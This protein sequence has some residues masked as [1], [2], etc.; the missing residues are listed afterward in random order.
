MSMKKDKEEFAF[1][2]LRE[3]LEFAEQLFSTI[4]YSHNRIQLS[5]QKIEEKDI[6][7]I[8]QQVL[9]LQKQLES[10]KE[11]LTPSETVRLFFEI[12]KNLGDERV[13]KLIKELIGGGITK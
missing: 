13:Q 12:L 2:E 7:D 11:E 4:E 8:I 1:E 5:T 3:P 9:S 10:R 6:F